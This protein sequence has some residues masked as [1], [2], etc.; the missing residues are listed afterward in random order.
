VVSANITA[1]YALHIGIHDKVY[2]ARDLQL[3][4]ALKCK[5][6]PHELIASNPG[7]EIEVWNRWLKSAGLNSSFRH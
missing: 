7:A 3:A 4:G 6:R 2:L 1:T 5:V